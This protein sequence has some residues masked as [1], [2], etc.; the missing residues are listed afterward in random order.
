MQTRTRNTASEMAAQENSFDQG[1]RDVN[2]FGQRGSGSVYQKR[3]ARNHFKDQMH[4]NRNYIYISKSSLKLG[5]SKKYVDM[6][7]SCSELQT[8]LYHL[9]SLTVRSCIMFVAFV[10]LS[11]VFCYSHDIHIIL[12][13]LSKFMFF[14]VCVWTY[15]TQVGV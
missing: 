14:F 5:E 7:L 6:H 8:T 1:K 2:H 13:D 4:V 11:F 15:Q 10:I 12:Q 9:I 3:S